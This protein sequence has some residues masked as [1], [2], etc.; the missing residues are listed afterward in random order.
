MANHDSQPIQDSRN[1]I[2][3][4]ST[5]LTEIASLARDRRREIIHA[6][7]EETARTVL[8]YV[9][10]GE[11]GVSEEDVRYFQELLSPLP[12]GASIDLLLHSNG[13]DASTA[14]KLVR[15]LRAVTVPQDSSIPKGE[16]R[17]I[18]P[19]RAKSAATLLA[20]GANRIVMSTTSELGTIDPQVP[21]YNQEGYAAWISVFDYLSAYDSVARRLESNPDDPVAQAEFSRFD[22]VQRRTFEQERDYVRMTAEN[23]LK[24][25]GA[26]FTLATHRLMDTTTFRAH[27][28]VIDWDVA[29]NYI[30]LNIDFMDSANALWKLY[31]K[32]YCYLRAA[33]QPRQKIFESDIVSLIV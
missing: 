32:L 4:E 10:D 3:E 33:I 26:N 7:Q 13:G 20:L 23:L 27:H 17:V 2:A 30:G 24:R 29:K 31:W 28:Q 5:P 16:L 11:A 12:P 8:C 19:D 22:P 25:Q 6:V 18:V 9:G 14:E 21:Q 1:P 15:M